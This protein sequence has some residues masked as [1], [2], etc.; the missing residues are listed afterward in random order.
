MAEYPPTRAEKVLK[1]S[2]EKLSEKRKIASEK[3]GRYASGV[4]FNRE[5]SK[6]A[7]SGLDLDEEDIDTMREERYQKGREKREYQKDKSIYYTRRL[8]A[9]AM[10][11][12]GVGIGV[13]KVKSSASDFLREHRRSAVKRA[14]YREEHGTFISKTKK[15]W[16]QSKEK[17]AALNQV[18][19]ELD[20]RNR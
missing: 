5:L 8:G 10:M 20:S 16:S 12:P 18:K 13:D 9:Y 11:V 15:H 2:K 6:I 7:N 1:Q 4:L 14:E 17:L 19:Q 3:M